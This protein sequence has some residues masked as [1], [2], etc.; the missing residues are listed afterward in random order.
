MV[1]NGAVGVRHRILMLI[2]LLNQLCKSFGDALL[3]DLIEHA[4]QHDAELLRAS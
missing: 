2:D 3:Y 4:A 1:W